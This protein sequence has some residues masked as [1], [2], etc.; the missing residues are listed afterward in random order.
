M[1]IAL[2]ML[3]MVLA[4]GTTVKVIEV[5]SFN[6]PELATAYGVAA[7]TVPAGKPLMEHNLKSLIAGGFG[8]L[9]PVQLTWV[10]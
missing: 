9:L 6:V 5:V 1:F 4:P 7:V 2:T 10:L 3:V 8:Q